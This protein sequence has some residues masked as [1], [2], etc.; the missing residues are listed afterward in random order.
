[1]GVSRRGVSTDENSQVVMEED[2]ER[3]QARAALATPV[4]NTFNNRS[5]NLT[6]SKRGFY[7]VV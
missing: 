2:E 3:E 4:L 5:V 1:M 6:T 7:E